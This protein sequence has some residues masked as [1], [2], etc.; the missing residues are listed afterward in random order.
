[1]EELTT[2][3]HVYLGLLYH[4]VEVLKGNDDFADELSTWSSLDEVFRK[5]LTYGIVSLDPPLPVYLFNVVAGMRDKSAKNYPIKKVR[6]F[7]SLRRFDITRVPSSSYYYC[8]NPCSHVVGEYVN[9]HELRPLHG[10]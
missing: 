8:G 2:E 3:I 5:R 7:H 1:M 6:R 9:L 10:N 4:I